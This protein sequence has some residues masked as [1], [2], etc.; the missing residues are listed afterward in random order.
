MDYDKLSIEE[1][2]EEFKKQY[3]KVSEIAGKFKYN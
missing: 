1:L 3:Y 2:Y